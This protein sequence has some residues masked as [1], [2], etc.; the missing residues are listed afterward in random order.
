MRYKPKFAGC[1]DYS[2]I[3]RIERI[4]RSRS[5][6]TSEDG[7]RWLVRFEE[8]NDIAFRIGKALPHIGR[9]HIID[10][11]RETT[12]EYD[13]GFLGYNMV[14]VKELI[15]TQNIVERNRR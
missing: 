2:L 4:I 8:I 11:S 15:E 14:V 12:V 6:D 5:G 10:F 3:K 9:R 13:K 1:Y 7:K